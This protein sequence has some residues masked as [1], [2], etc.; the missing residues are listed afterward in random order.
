MNNIRHF[1]FLV[2]GSGIAGLSFALKVAPHGRVA[3]ITKKNRAESNTNYAQGGIAAVTSKEDSFESHVRDTL[4]AGAGLCD[5]AVVRTI[6]QEGPARIAELI[7][8]GMHFSER[9]VSAKSGVKELD[10]GREGGHSQRRILH[11]QDITGREIE[12]ALLAAVNQQPNIEIFENHFAIDLITTQKLGLD[13]PN[14]CVGVYVLVNNRGWVEAFAAPVVLLATGGCG[15]VYLYTTNPD[16]ATGDGVAMASRAGTVIA[17]MEFIQFHPT[18][19]YHPKAK[20]FLISEA[21]RG[22]GGVLKT[23]EGVEF[24]DRYHPLKSLAP[25]DV[26]AR[27]IDREMKRTGADHVLLD[28]THQPA[29]FLIKRFPNIHKTCLQYGIDITKEPI[30]VV[31]AAHYQC[32]GV[33]TTVDGETEIVGLYAVGEVAC[34]GLHGANRL[35]SNSLLE[36]LVCAHRAAERV[37][38]GDFL[39]EKI[40][41]PPWQ[42]GNAHNAD[43]LVV[44]SHN[45]DEIRRLMWDYVGIVRT[46]KR[47]KRARARIANLQEEI[48]QYYW[49]FI[50][51]SDLLEL[52]NI[53]TVAELIVECALDR[54]ESRGLH[55]NLD[56][57]EPNPE[58]AKRDT[59]RRR[60]L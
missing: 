36:A 60:P 29:E 42:S 22:E 52:R 18:C 57:P 43:E 5:E 20:S 41:L 27:A 2:L 8:L 13:G 45:W 59:M 17:N 55:Y 14:R 4:E 31:P 6:V 34:T 7:Q 53:A 26:V 37:V 16:I 12:R 28:I 9:E 19:L 3:I 33:K 50:V 44:V 51:T 25:R 54:P 39:R 11:A 49:D 10:L 24:M 30:P 15:K 35:A 46:N 38:G 58:W 47:L 40:G 23:L 56:F 32:G 21:V 1:D 48:Q